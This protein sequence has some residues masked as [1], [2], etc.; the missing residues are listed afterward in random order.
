M[1]L[2]L[3]IAGAA[4]TLVGL[5][6]ERAMSDDS[7][8]DFGGIRTFPLIALLGCVGA[9]LAPSF[10]PWLL[11]AMLGAVTVLIAISHAR[12]GDGNPGLT[13]EIAALVTFGAGAIAGTEGLLET[14]QRYL[15]VTAISAVTMTLLAVKKPLHGLVARVSPDDLYATAK[16]V[17]LALVVIPILP[18]ETYGPLDVLNPAKMGMMI[19]LVAGISFVGYVAAR[20]LGSGRGLLLTGLVGGLVSST[21]VTLTFAGKAKVEPKV[22]GVSA[23]AIGAASATM[24]ARIVAVVSAVDP[25]LLGRIAPPML[26][27]AAAGM[28]VAAL[29]YRREVSGRKTDAL[30]LRNPFELRTAIK[31]GLLYGVVLFVAK[32]A[33][34]YL[35]TAGV[36]GS[37]VLAGL[38]D[39]DAITVSLSQLHRQGMSSELAS[40]GITLAA[41]TN[42]IVKVTLAASLGGRSLGLRVGAVLGSAILAGGAALLVMFLA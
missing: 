1:L 2:D 42:T 30:P 31:F 28:L 29:L 41:V 40:L 11:L 8:R 23:V 14:T 39:V 26:A 15:L 38:T 33:Q 36:L 22:A 24:F 20:V 32:A 37:A 17:I 34:V 27:M 5:E 25:P 12:A 7:E 18:D 10:G 19:A 16:F 4:G 21:A 6:R 9:L 35:G 3:A 13:S